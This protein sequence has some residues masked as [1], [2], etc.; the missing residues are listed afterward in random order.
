MKI[1]FK[2][3]FVL[4]VLFTAIILVGFSILTES[5]GYARR[6]LDSDIP[7]IYK[8][9][10][11][12]P[13][14]YSGPIAAGAQVWED[15]VSSYWE[16]ESGGF[17]S[18]SSVA[19]DGTNLVF[20]DSEGV[21]FTPG[22]NTIAFSSTWTSGSGSNYH[23]IESDLIWNARD[24]AP[25]PTGASGQ[26][27]L[28]S[29]IAHE[30]GHHLGL[31]HAG[32]AGG[33][34]GVGPLIPAA[35]MYGFSSNGDTSKRSLHI[36]DIAGVSSIYPTWTLQGIITEAQSGLP[37]SSSALSADVTFAAEVDAPISGNGVYQRPGY[38]RNPLIVAEDGTFQLTA[39]VQNFDLTAS[40][41][42]YENQ[43]KT[44]S[45]QDPGG[46]GQTEN[47]FMVFQLQPSAE[48]SVNGILSDSL[49]G[50]PIEAQISVFVVSDK[51]GVPSTSII[52]TTTGISGNFDLLL[53]INEDYLLT[54]NP[55]APYARDSVYIQN[56]SEGGL[57]LDL[58]LYP[59]EVLLVNDDLSDSFEVEITSAL[60]H[61]NR[62]YHLWRI[63]ETGIPDSFIYNKF[64]EPRTMIWYSG[65]AV[66]S[67]LTA[68]EQLKI[69]QFLDGG[70]HLILTGQ[71]IAE[72]SQSGILLND[73]LSVAFEKNVNFPLVSGVANDPIGDGLVFTTIGAANNQ[74]SRDELK[75]TGD[76]NAFLNYGFDPILGIA[77]VRAEGTQAGWKA[78]L[79]GFGLEA[80][81]NSE[82]LRDSLVYRILNWFELISSINGD[83]ENIKANI[84]PKFEL[85]QNY[86]NPFNPITYIQ[87]LIP[88][89]TKVKISIFNTIGQ[90]VKVLVDKDYIS[91]VFQ[92]AWDG[93]NDDGHPMPSGIYFYKMSTA[94]GFQETKKLI[95]LK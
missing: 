62:S 6:Y 24:F 5:S 68:E 74:T 95:L 36:D 27:D 55:E 72:S 18:D 45:F 15:V 19:L 86:P 61:I 94:S 12:T 47:I 8:L 82:G 66:D 87:F 46:I 28:Q 73:Y 38:Y 59:A 41:F 75:I 65:N 20:F 40:F 48:V 17:T 44:V 26:Q 89:S 69:A 37:L 63:S 79:M 29:V 9:N 71:N 42:G 22:T 93:L 84:P 67:V 76:A 78:V 16:F 91:G 54:I 23:A 70:G 49:T 83:V 34:P 81:N 52:D 7:F 64:F 33:P 2:F 56:L 53:P 57:Q 21:N 90:E 4:C 77:A 35:T 11:S 85:H 1:I 92:V 14:E 88:R 58:K 60:S 50:T 32:P 25:S 3:I 43:T 80:V 39:L 10:D 30:L 31:G 13:P 51:P